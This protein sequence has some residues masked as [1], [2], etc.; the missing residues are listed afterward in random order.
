VPAASAELTAILQ[1]TATLAAY[2]DLVAGAQETPE[3]HDDLAR[4]LARWIAVDPGAAAEWIATRAAAAPD[5]PGLDP[6]LA[7]LSVHLTARG[8]YGV[9]REWAEAI[10]SP[11][12]RA[13]ALEELLAERYRHRQLDPAALR[14]AAASDG[15]PPERVAAILDYSRLD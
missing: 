8:A 14:A 4:T 3:Q 10:R 7:Q 1:L 9:A 11:E 6:A 5:D 15:L 12:V 13:L 2:A